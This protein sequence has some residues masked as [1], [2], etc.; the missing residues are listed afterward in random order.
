V[1]ERYTEDV[2]LSVAKVDQAAA[3]TYVQDMIYQKH[4][5]E[6]MKLRVNL[7]VVLEIDNQGTVDLTTNWS[8]G[9]HPHHMDVPQMF[10]H[11]PKEDGI[12]LIKWVPG[13]MN[14]VDLHTKTLAGS[15]FEKHVEVYTGKDEYLST[16]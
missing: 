7:P 9:G 1:E 2:A 8:A 4:L 10:L 15:S 3:I 14:D 12:I 5:F 11:R 6:S 13:P 16:S